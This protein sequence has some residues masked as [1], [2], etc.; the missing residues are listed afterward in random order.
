MTRKHF[1]TAAE[2][3]SRITD[4][5]ERVYLANKMADVFEEL[6]KRF[7]REKFLKACMV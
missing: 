1:V 7:D 4:P 5:N 6:N 3:I 2:A